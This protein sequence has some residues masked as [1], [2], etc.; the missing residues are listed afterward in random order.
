MAQIIF[1]NRWLNCP[2]EVKRYHWH[3]QIKIQEAK[4]TFE[5]ETRDYNAFQK[6]LSRQ[7]SVNLC[8]QR[9]QIVREICFDDV[10]EVE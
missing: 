7:K 9:L 6:S 5:Y 3:L 1:L 8:R 2:D 10:D 4:A